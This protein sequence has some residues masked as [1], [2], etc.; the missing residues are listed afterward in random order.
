M[1]NLNIRNWIK[2]SRLLCHPYLRCKIKDRGFL[3]GPIWHDNCTAWT[4]KP[5]SQ[6][7]PQ[8]ALIIFQTQKYILPPT[9]NKRCIRF[10]L[11]SKIPN[12]GKRHCFLYVNRENEA[13]KFSQIWRAPKKMKFIMKSKQIKLDLPTF[14]HFWLKKNLLTF[15]NFNFSETVIH[16][17]FE[18]IYT[19]QKWIA[20]VYSGCLSIFWDLDF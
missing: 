3:K 20:L 19:D 1:I 5:L 15:Q 18:Q 9:R 13:K 14:C 17:A 16:R 2:F 4:K 10:F 7:R 11:L 12:S 6:N 8:V